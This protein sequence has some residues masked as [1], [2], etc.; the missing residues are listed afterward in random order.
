[1]AARKPTFAKRPTIGPLSECLERLKELREVWGLDDGDGRRGDADPLWFRGHADAGWKLTPK[2]YRPEY[3][4]SP[5]NVATL[6]LITDFMESSVR[7]LVGEGV[8]PSNRFNI[9]HFNTVL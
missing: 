7:I 8:T 4:D 1:M 9:M 6:V 2:L 5:T 3:R